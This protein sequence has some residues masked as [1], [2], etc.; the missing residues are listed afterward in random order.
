MLRRARS[1]LPLLL[2]GA[3]L[4]Q[5]GR[6]APT[7]AKDKIP[8]DFARFVAVG[9]G[10]HFDTAITT[11]RNAAGVEVRLFAAV[12]IAD[13]ALYAAL[14]ERF[15]A[16]DALLYELVGPEDYRP[17]RG[18]GGTGSFVSLLQNGLKSGLEL[19]F[20]LDGIDY[21][22]PN[23]V[24]ADMTPQE[25]EHSMSERGETL[26]GLI[27]KMS[28]KSTQVAPD[29]NGAAPGGPSFDL[30]KAFR[31]G[32]GRHRLRV[33]LASQLEQLEAVAAGAGD[34]G[35]GSTLLEGRNEKCLE[36]LQ[37]EIAAGKKKLGIYYGAAHLTHMER[38]LCDDLGFHKVDH[39]WLLA[40][41][42]TPRPDPK[43]DRE[44]WAARRQAKAQIA[45]IA[46]AVDAWLRATHGEGAPTF[47]QLQQP[48]ADGQP[49]YGGPTQ[50][51]W[52]HDYVIQWYAATPNVDV[53]SL[54]QDGVADAS[55]GR[56]DDLHSAS[57]RDLARMRRGRSAPADKP[58][59]GPVP[60][61]LDD[62]HRESRQAKLTKA[63][64]DVQT[65]LLA[66]RTFRARNN[67][68]PTLQE[69]TATDAQGHAWLEPVSADP[70]G[71]DYVV[72]P[73]AGGTAIDVRS[74]GPDG[75]LDTDDDVV[76]G[77]TPA[78]GGR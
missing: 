55:A 29:G 44:L 32:E 61:L 47:A 62:L 68:L 17:K 16:C 11:Y 54:G 30:V 26:L 63:T 27:W 53:Q 6:P 28:L 20:Q 36:V 59:P 57:L 33:M 8:S 48:G 42:C 46:A 65:I 5:G 19:E 56:G 73:G 14:Q 38:R 2:V 21:S 60:G 66:A 71:N 18:E 75:K 10:G 22:A 64:T 52:G 76:A 40:W 58:G 72:R 12:H 15:A 49:Y 3:A 37:R 74:A 50:D 13:A 43:V 31:S 7:D 24:H 39:E 69:L 45:A 78:A 34:D 23:F 25:F 41:D 51:P 35:K 9:D 4:A 67:R 70:W 77:K 1:L